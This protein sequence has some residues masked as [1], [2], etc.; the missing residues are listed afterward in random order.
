MTKTGQTTR[1]STVL[2]HISKSILLTYAA[3][4]VTYMALFIAIRCQNWELR[5]SAL[6]MMAPVLT[7]FNCTTYRKL[8]PHNLADIQRFPVCV[9]QGLEQGT[10]TVNILGNKGHAVAPD[11][12]HKMCIQ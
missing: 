2:A 1:F 4:L 7:T 10:F 11:E 8:V 9:L 12:A 3:W 6:K 5:V